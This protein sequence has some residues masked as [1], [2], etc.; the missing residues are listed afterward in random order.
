MKN[1]HGIVY[2]DGTVFLYSFAYK[3]RSKLAF[4]AAILR[5][6]DVTWTTVNT[7]LHYTTYIVGSY[8]FPAAAA[9][10]DGKILLCVNLDHWCILTPDDDNASRKL[11]PLSAW[12]GRRGYRSDSYILEFRGQLLWVSVLVRI[13][14]SDPAR[15]VSLVVHALEQDNM[16]WVMAD[17][18]SLADHVLF[19]GSRSSFFMDAAVPEGDSGCAYLL[20]GNVLLRYTFVHDETK[21]VD[22]INDPDWPIN[23]SQN[24]HWLQPQPAIAPI[25]DIRKRLEGFNLQQ[26]FILLT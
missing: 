20:F 14:E 22:H 10:H 19:L 7:M 5:P 6:R 11:Q 25:Q 3:S 26:N 12:Y 17:V 13:G 8:L 21:L 4:M 24:M 16:R 23:E 1:P 9:Y 15:A 2:A 18:R